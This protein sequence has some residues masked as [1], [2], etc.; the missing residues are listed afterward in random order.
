MS[1]LGATNG[2]ATLSDS[3]Q[4]HILNQPNL[5]DIHREFFPHVADRILSHLQ[6]ADTVTQYPAHETCVSIHFVAWNSYFVTVVY[7]TKRADGIIGVRTIHFSHHESVVRCLVVTTDGRVV[8]TKEHRVIRKQTVLNLPGGG[9]QGTP[10]EVAITEVTEESGCA[11]TPATHVTQ[12]GHIW[13]EDGCVDAPVELIVLDQ[14]IPNPTFH[15]NQ[16]DIDSV[17]FIPWQEWHQKALAGEYDDHYCTLFAARCHWNPTTQ[18]IEVNGSSKT[19][20]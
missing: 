15:N 19:L 18:K 13:P 8:M 12:I 10:K 5:E 3:A 4:V 7:T 16:E 11:L 20:V 9:D 17:S 6:S 1:S 14:V 2:S